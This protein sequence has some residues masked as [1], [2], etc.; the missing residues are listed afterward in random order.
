MYKRRIWFLLI[1]LMLGIVVVGCGSGKRGKNRITERDKLII[2]AQDYSAI[3][4][5]YLKYLNDRKLNDILFLFADGATVENPVGGDI[6]LGKVSLRNF[7]SELFKKEASYTRTGEVRASGVE[8]AF[9]F[10]IRKDIDGT[11]TIID[12]IEVFRFD[13]TDKIISVRSFWGPFNEKPA[14]E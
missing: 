6:I 14:N 8:I 4:D 3:A 2:K 9:P 12:V 5:D 1:S 7:Y 10:Q 13:S 11:P